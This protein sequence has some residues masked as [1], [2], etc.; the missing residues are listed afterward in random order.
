MGEPLAKDNSHDAAGDRMNGK[1]C[2][3]TGGGSGIGRAAALRMAEEGAAAVVVAG[4]REAEIEATALACRAFGAQALAV[5]TDVTRED[6]VEH[7][8]GAALD[9]F[10]RLD[11]AF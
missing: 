4:R 7:L 3:I 1:V 5:R 11:A 10:G 9:R 6:E 8:V 2:L